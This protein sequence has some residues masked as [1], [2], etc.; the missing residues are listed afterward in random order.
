MPVR[1]HNSSRGPYY[2]WGNHGKRY[3]YIAGDKRSRA[4]AKQK[5]MAQGRAAHAAGYRGRGN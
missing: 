1:R 5:A 2:Q 3:Y 4:I